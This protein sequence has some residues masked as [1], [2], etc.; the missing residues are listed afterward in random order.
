MIAHEMQHWMESQ[1][2]EMVKIKMKMQMIQ[3]QSLELIQETRI[4]K[5][6]QNLA[7][8]K[9]KASTEPH[10]TIIRRWE[11]AVNLG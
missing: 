5:R 7:L 9:V 10:F 2:I 3:S 6:K 11:S 4:A 1:E 8:R